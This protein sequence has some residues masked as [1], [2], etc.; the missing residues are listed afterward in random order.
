[1]DY[2]PFGVACDQSPDP[3]C[4]KH[5]E[6]RALLKV[7]LANKSFT[8]V[9]LRR[10]KFIDAK[11]Q[12]ETEGDA[13]VVDC[14]DGTIP[15]RNSI[16]IKVR[17]RLA[18]VFKPDDNYPYGVW[19][20][21]KDFPKTLHQNQPRVGHPASLCLY[22]ESWD[23]ERRTWTPEKHLQRVLW[24]LRETANGTLHHSDQPLEQFYFLSDYEVV[25]PYNFVERISDESLSLQ[26]KVVV[27]DGSAFKTIRAEFVN[28]V[29][30]PVRQENIFADFLTVNVPPVRHSGVENFPYTLG[31]LQNQLERRGSSLI[32]SLRAAI[33]EK[34]PL[35]GLKLPKEYRPTLLVIS[36]PRLRDGADT[37]EKTDVVGFIL[38]DDICRLGIHAG[39]LMHTPDGDVY[40][41]TPILGQADYMGSSSNH[42][43]SCEIDE[44]VTVKFEASQAYARLASGVSEECSTLKGLLAGVGA[45]GSVLADLWSKEGWGTWTYVDDD[46]L[47]PHNVI[48]HLGRNLHIG[49]YK[50]DVVKNMTNL[51]YA[52]GLGSSV[53]L[54]GKVSVGTS[55]AITD[56]ITSSQLF[57]DATT[58]IYA[59]RDIASLEEAPRS[60]SVFLTPDGKSSVLLLEDK[61]QTV[62]L[63]NL[64]AQYYRAIL[65]N[66]WGKTHY[67]GHLG[68]LVVGG[69][70]RDVSAVISNE[71]IQLHGSMLARQI[72]TQ[73]ALPDARIRIWQL[74]DESG[75]LHSVSV[76]VES[77]VQIALGQWT[78]ML[79]DGL[80][81]K[82]YAERKR[83]LPKETGGILLGYIDQ[84]L[85]ST[86]IVDA[87]PA[88]SDSEADTSGFVRGTS[89]LKEQL[90]E[91]SR[92]T[93][94]IVSY[95]GEWH[96]H[97]PHCSVS[98]SGLD[99]DLL[100][101]L[102]EKM[103]ADGLPALM[104]IIGEDETSIAQGSLV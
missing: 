36:I 26:L 102:A 49:S 83:H 1:M 92:R 89:G 87:L 6:T 65:N 78:A 15:S 31:E 12:V 11:T 95:V 74:N 25:L 96:S 47:K 75:E 91:C 16:G 27:L 84:K 44:P 82:L 48:R 63:S 37:T 98:P 79:D 76:P 85:H 57:V 50:A 30:N 17:E 33:S 39:V 8:V 24:W 38:K 32:E 101:Y 19:A 5:D 4:L 42:W 51:N 70:C 59:P 41:D 97:P 69:G 100:S 99:L 46:I 18:L 9:E 53:A 10:V 56:A 55:P 86:F 103:K 43:M 93:A 73:T 80:C 13:I 52:G 67:E 3:T 29:P 28:R 68:A 88:P 66:D 2:I 61:E 54:I 7:C 23:A 94:N 77:P 71:L 14:C 104:L 58:T 21:R 34:C 81:N 22:F 20:L 62:R 72:R 35:T 60:A 45:L 90:D 64:E 40:K